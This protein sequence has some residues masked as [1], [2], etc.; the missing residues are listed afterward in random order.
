VEFTNCKFW[1]HSLHSFCV[2]VDD[3]KQVETGVMV[4]LYSSISEA[5]RSHLSQYT[6]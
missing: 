3:L 1:V 2:R 4:M 6:T 5:T